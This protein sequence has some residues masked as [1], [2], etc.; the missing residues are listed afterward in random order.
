[1]PVS[2]RPAAFR[3]TPLTEPPGLRTALIPVVVAPAITETR[4][5][6][7]ITGSALSHW[8]AYLVPSQG[9]NSAEKLPG[10]RSRTWCGPLPLTCAVACTSGARADGRLGLMP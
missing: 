1:M 10:R 2:R 3:T 9:P 4:L 8:V 7:W 6:D 5:A